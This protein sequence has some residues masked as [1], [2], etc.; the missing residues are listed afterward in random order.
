VREQP[1]NQSDGDEGRHRADRRVERMVA[2]RVQ[3]RRVP[4]LD[5]QQRGRED[6]RAGGGQGAR[7]RRPGEDGDGGQQRG[8]DDARLLQ[9]GP[10]RGGRDRVG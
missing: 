6:E 7:A 1:R 5:E 10:E 2:Q 8:D 9:T 4:D 3:L